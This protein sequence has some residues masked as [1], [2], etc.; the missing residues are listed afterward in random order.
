M[1]AVLCATN[2]L[3]DK[4]NELVRTMLAED[5]ASHGLPPGRS[6]HAAVGAANIGDDSG[7]HIFAEQ[8]LVDDVDIMGRGLDKGL[9]L[10]D[11]RISVGD[12]VLLAKNMCA[13]S[14][15]VKNALFHVAAT[16]AKSIV[17]E[18][19]QQQRWTVPRARFIIKLNHEGTISISQ[20]QIPVTHAWA[21][22][23]NKSQGQTCEATLLDLRSKYFEHGQAYTAAGRTPTAA[24]TGAFVSDAC[25]VP[26]PGGGRPVPIMAAICHPQLL[27]RD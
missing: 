18:D 9:P 7:E 11:L 2:L 20:K 8:A 19:G 21:L 12:T 13:D 26:R 23:V 27:A 15:L 6:Y 3:K 14:G 25:S 5:A 4:W 24:V 17:L 10:N 22:T 16:R 1:R